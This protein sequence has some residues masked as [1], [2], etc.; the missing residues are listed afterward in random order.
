M[1]LTRLRLLATALATSLPALVQAEP[2]G[3]LIEP[4][5]V[6]D[7]GS[8]SVGVLEEVKAERGDF[9]SAG[10]VLARLSTGVERASLAVAE[11][12][13]RADAE[14]KAAQAAADLARNKLDR[15]RDLIKSN[16]ISSQALEQAQAEARVA[17]QRAQQARDA[18]D[19][20]Q[21]EFHLSSAQLGQRFIRAPFEGIVVERYRTQGE[22]IEREPV[23]K[24]ARIHPLRIEAIVPAALFGTIQSGQVGQVRPQLTQFGTLQ[25]S[26]TVVDRV[27]D[28]ASNSF[29]V[30]LTLPNP[31]H[32]IPSGLRCTVDFDP[33]PAAPPRSAA[34]AAPGAPA[35]PAR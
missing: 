19:V 18:R 35:R 5:R 11:S 3:C 33:A 2:F 12:R 10:Q 27:V 29:R 17:D 9:V 13:A 7:V 32:R 24:I 21:R 28:A 30:R 16:F 26:V 15:A 1:T 14:V 25:A 34:P 20:A 8:A 6:A 23:V 4:D 22:R 31:D